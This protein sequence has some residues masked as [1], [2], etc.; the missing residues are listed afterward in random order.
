MSICPK[1]AR[2]SYAFDEIRYTRSAHEVPESSWISWNRC[3]G[4][5]TFWR[6]WNYV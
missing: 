1:F 4:G 2:H 3:R 5:R 6:I